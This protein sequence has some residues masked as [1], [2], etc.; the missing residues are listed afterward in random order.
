ME[1]PRDILLEEVLVS[2]D[3]S[4]L[5]PV[6]TQGQSHIL[7]RI[8]A[9]LAKAHD[10]EVLALNVA[11]VPR[12]LEL[13][14]GRAFLR[15]GR[16]SLETVIQEAS[17]LDV[18]V[19]TMIRLGRDVGKAVRKTAEENASDLIVLGWPGYTNTAGRAF[20]SVIDNVLDNPP[21]DIVVVRYREERPLKSILVPVA[22]GPNSRLAVRLAVTM[23]KGAT[24]ETVKVTALRV[25]P[26][27][28][29]ES[30]ILRAQ[31]D[32]AHSVEGAPPYELSLKVAQGK[33]VVNTILDAAK[34]YDLIVIGATNEPLFNTLLVGTIPEQVAKRAEVTTMMVKLHHGAFK[35]LLRETVLQPAST[36]EV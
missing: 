18:P 9:I 34:T 26:E 13:S 21:T 16:P 36:K 28:A 31:K 11:L 25:V 8:A 29:S 33:D 20:G 12:Q 1:K 15:E 23:A 7:G 6:T 4:V 14:D 35:S 32:L 2:R 30:D 22:G 24:E 10:G 19:H 17:K 3:Y 27:S 5:V